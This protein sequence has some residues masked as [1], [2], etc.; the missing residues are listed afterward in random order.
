MK[1]I[2]LYK[3][4]LSSLYLFLLCFIFVVI[5]IFMV[6]TEGSFMAWFVLLVFGLGALFCLVIIFDKRPQIIISKEGIW[7]R[8]AIWTK[9]DAK[10]IIEW[11]SI[12]EVYTRSVENSKFICL[13][14]VQTKYKEQNLVQ[15]KLAKLN[16][17]MGFQDLNI[18]L[19]L[20]KIDEHKLVD[21]LNS[22]TVS[23]EYQR[24]YLI[25]NFIIPAPKNFF[26]K[27]KF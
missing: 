7:R 6:I 21:F 17:E 24:E 10:K 22:M 14:P 12:K 15:K 27:F 18:N 16:I 25:Q 5:G 1:E 20:I 11:N 9:Y 26:S 23:D 2:K 3:S 13:I 4:S 8:K 19:T